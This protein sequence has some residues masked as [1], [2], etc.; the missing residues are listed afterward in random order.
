MAPV[1]V[2]YLMPWI[3]AVA[4]QHPQGHGILAVTLLLGWTGVV[5]LG[6]LAYALSPS[7]SQPR[8]TSRHLRLVTPDREGPVDSR[9]GLRSRA[10]VP[11]LAPGRSPHSR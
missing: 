3:A 5:W 6:A 10:R 4:A 1:L 8:G 9:E 2:I 11:P 7:P